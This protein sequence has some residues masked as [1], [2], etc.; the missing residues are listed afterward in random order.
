MDNFYVQH[1]KSKVFVQLHAHSLRFNIDQFS[2][3]DEE[4]A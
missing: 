4:L 2:N 3:P 1:R